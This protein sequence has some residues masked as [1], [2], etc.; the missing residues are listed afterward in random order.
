MK[1]KTNKNI[2]KKN[3]AYSLISGEPIDISNCIQVGEEI[4]FP[5]YDI[6][7]KIQKKI[8]KQPPF[9]FINKKFYHS[10]NAINNKDLFKPK[11]N[12]KQIIY[13][14]GI[15]KTVTKNEK[16][17]IINESIDYSN[18]KNTYIENLKNKLN[19]ELE[20][21]VNNSFLLYNRKPN[22]KKIVRNPISTKVLSEKI[23]IWK[24]YIKDLNTEEKIHLFRKFLFYVE[25]FTDNCY[26]QFLEI[27]EINDAYKLLLSKYDK[28]KKNKEEENEKKFLEKLLN[29]FNLMNKLI[30]C[31]EKGN[32]II[33]N[34]KNDA[35][36]RFDELNFKS[37]LF[38]S[39]ILNLKQEFEGKGYGYSFLRELRDI[40]NMFTNVS[41][42]FYSV[43]QDCYKIF[44]LKDTEEIENIKIL[45]NIFSEYFI[46]NTFVLWF[47]IQLKS[48]FGSYKQYE[49]IK[50]INK[51]VLVKNNAE[52][53]LE[54]IKEQI[55]KI[56]GL[57]GEYD[58]Y[59]NIHKMKNIDDI[60]KYIEGDEDKINKKHKKKKKKINN[61]NINID[62]IEDKNYE[63]E[64]EDN[65]YE[66]IDDGLSIISEADSVLDDFRN[67]IMAETE[68]NLG[69]KITPILSSDFLNKY[70][71][72]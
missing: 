38:T 6:N 59:K 56:I 44:E 14:S 52:N 30:G 47:L 27:K 66:D 12:I 10:E 17:E 68:F 8:L 33:D 61:I 2:K 23:L 40:A 57:P 34:E 25:K 49:M 45:W 31:D 37:V 36:K 72:K 29:Q 54:K 19:E 65:Y 67:D 13:P 18:L 39:C 3:C 42:I 71:A 50:F 43:F 63:N 69:N 70:L 41:I 58:D 53:S 16:D 48:L 21:L 64:E 7:K 20:L 22:I 9:E 60:M 24:Y 15:I 46:D 62:N 28:N 51:F 26:K 1:K 35:E 32:I 4:K 55:N 11:E 5:E